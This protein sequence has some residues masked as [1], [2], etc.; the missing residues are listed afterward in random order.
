MQVVSDL[1]GQALTAT[2][3][4]WLREDLEDMR[5]KV[6]AAVESYAATRERAAYEEAANLIESQEF[7][8]DFALSHPD[9]GKKMAAK[10][11]ALAGKAAT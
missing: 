3:D 8:S 1:E 10:V 2:E 6:H 9:G 11:R 7:Q 4:G 5:E